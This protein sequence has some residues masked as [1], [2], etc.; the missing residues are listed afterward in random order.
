M[1]TEKRNGLEQVLD[2]AMSPVMPF[3]LRDGRDV[4]GAKG[5]SGRHEHE[6]TYQGDEQPCSTP[7]ESHLCACS[8]VERWKVG[9]GGGFKRGAYGQLARAALRHVAALALKLVDRRGTCA[10]ITAARSKSDSR[11]MVSLIRI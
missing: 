10:Q 2:V 9:A 5:R 1:M 4:A 6:K 11:C 8:V 7:R 3:D